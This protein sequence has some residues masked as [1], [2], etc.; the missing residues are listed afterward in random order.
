MRN[1]LRLFFS[2]EG[3]NPWIILL[4]LVTASIV[5]GI[6]LVSL[7]PLLMVATDTGSSKA[8]PLLDIARDALATSGCR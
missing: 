7:V 3:I 2:A 5:E 6:G 4:C 1:I 8:S